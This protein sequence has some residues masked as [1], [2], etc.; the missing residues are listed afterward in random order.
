[1]LKVIVIRVC[2][3]VA[4]YSNSHLLLIT[5]LDSYLFSSQKCNPKKC[6]PLKCNPQ[7]CYPKK[8][9]CDKLPSPNQKVVEPKP[10]DSRAQIKI[11]RYLPDLGAVSSC[12]FVFCE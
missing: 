2:C 10:K 1:M 11:K 4:S 12:A 5:Y 3:N 6:Y 8:C 9:N 7:K